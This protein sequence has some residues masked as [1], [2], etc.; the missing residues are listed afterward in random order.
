MKFS[1][2]YWIK[3]A[4]Y[5]VEHPRFIQGVE[6][7]A[8][9]FRAYAL[10]R[11]FSHAGDEL[12]SPLLTVSVDAIAPDMARVRLENY[13]GALPK[14]PNFSLAEFPV[15]PEVEVG[16]QTGWLRTGK[17]EVRISPEDGYRLSFGAEGREFTS[18]IL[19]SSGI[20]TTPEKR[21]Y[22]HE[23]LT[24]AVG[25]VVYGLGERFGPVAKNGQTV[26]LWNDDGGTATEHAYKNV[27]F[28]F[29]NAGYGVFVDDPGLVSLEVGSEVNSRV[30]FSVEGQSLEYIVIY[31]PAPK[32]ILA[33]Y[34]ALTGRP[35]QVPAWSYGLWLSTSFTTDYREETA[36]S[37]IDQME[38]KGLPLSV[39]HF[40]CYWM[41]PSHW[42][43]FTWDPAKFPDPEQ[44]LQRFHDRGIKVCVWINPYIGQRSHLFEEGRKRGYLLK[45][46]DGSVRQWDHWQSG[47]AWVD[48]T[49]PEATAWWKEELKKLLRQG[50]D[51]FKTDFGERVPTDVVWADGS[52]PERMHNYYSYLY[53]QAAYEAIA[54]ERG[55]EEAIVFARAATAGGQQFPVHWG[56]DSEPTFVSMAETLRGG[57]SLGMSGF[58]Y[59]SHDMGG[60]EGTPRDDVFI[61]WFPF[62]MLSSHSR[63]HGSHSYR[64]PWNY[65]DTAVQVARRFIRLKNRLMP[66]IIHHARA[67]T[68]SGTP[69][70]RHLILEYP[71][72]RGSLHVDTEYLFGPDLLVA[73]VFN[74]EGEV[75][76]Y[77]PTDGWTDLLTGLRLE[78][79]GWHRQHHDLTSLPVLVPD[80]SVIPLG[81][82]SARPD[83]DWDQ[84][85]TLLLFYPVSGTREIALPTADGSEV[86]VTVSREGQ[87]VT[88]ST[89]V[90]LGDWRVKLIGHE[91][92]RVLIGSESAASG[93]PDLAPGPE[94]IPEGDRVKFILR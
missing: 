51:C 93:E 3:K 32:E 55:V 85:V 40:D 30:Q 7:S 18:S 70:M 53:N 59:W 31:G 49:N 62:G 64:V 77:L 60:F 8:T 41:R 29:T 81:A 56:G 14:E 86:T 75:D 84:N 48:F 1:E 16:D 28:Y 27:P 34:T 83:Y 36:I 63:L 6:A 43:D 4:G 57:L 46:A 10:T 74:S 17:L 35:P 5:Q 87:M 68:E 11:R 69:L 90:P 37:F 89:E 61:R 47:M 50:V 42:C 22:L 52:D 88:V 21:T 58:G 66:Y 92:E 54:E 73:P 20:V 24:L 44:M 82:E 23:Q 67:T 91:V 15:N 39:F 12:D 13:R 65:G 25:E 9:G 71:E 26:D 45:R 72:D 33:K 2:G 38:E 76:V 80:G 79:S 19:K 78:R 94:F